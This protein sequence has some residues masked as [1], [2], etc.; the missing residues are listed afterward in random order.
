MGKIYRTTTTINYSHFGYNNSL[1]LVNS[2]YLFPRRYYS[3]SSK[4][5]TSNLITSNLVISSEQERKERKAEIYKKGFP[6]VFQNMS[7]MK[8]D[9]YFAITKSKFRPITLQL[10][11]KVS[12]I[13]MISNKV[14]K[15]I[16]IGMSSDLYKRFYS[17]LNI[18]KLKYDGGSR[19]NK[20]LIKYGF[21]N[22][23]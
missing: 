15:K 8:D 7:L 19:I 4:L 3:D 21:E 11:N 16:Y 10:L 2:L 5:D 17:Y 20:A 6:A 12:G 18:S 23:S 22:F 1:C 14:T 13:Y 9:N